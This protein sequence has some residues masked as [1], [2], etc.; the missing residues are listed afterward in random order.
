MLRWQN[1]QPRWWTGCMGVWEGGC[2]GHVYDLL[3]GYRWVPLTE[4][5]NSG[6]EQVWSGLEARS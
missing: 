5:E 3:N 4:M 1:N 2:Q 6:R